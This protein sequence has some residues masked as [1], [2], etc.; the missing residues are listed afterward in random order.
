MAEFNVK[1][2]V[3]LYDDTVRYFAIQ[4]QLILL[5][6][7]FC[8]LGS[9]SAEHAGNSWSMTGPGEEEQYKIDVLSENDQK[10]GPLQIS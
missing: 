6:G 10:Q 5:C 3:S 4:E 9:L 1:L 7:R 8:Q 2:S